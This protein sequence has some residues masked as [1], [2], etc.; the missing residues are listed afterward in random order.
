MTVFHL[1]FIKEKILKEMPLVTKFYRKYTSQ[2]ST[3]H[4]K[5]NLRKPQPDSLLSAYTGGS[6]LRF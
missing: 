1:G 5:A 2:E 6:I 3:L 4:H